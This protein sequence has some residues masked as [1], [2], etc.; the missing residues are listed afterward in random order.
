MK[1]T[2][3]TLSGCGDAGKTTMARHCIAPQRGGRILTFESRSA[4]GEESNPIDRDALVAHLFAAA[5]TG[6]VIDV[7]VGDV[8]D[9][10]EALQLLSRQ[11]AAIAQRLRIV[12]PLLAE[13]KSV[14]GLAWLLSQ[15][16]P[17][18][19]PAVR[20]IWNRIPPGGEDGLRTSDPCRAAR[21]LE[22]QHKFR[23]CGPAL[24]ESPLL[25]ATHSLLAERGSLEAI[26]SMRDDELRAAPLVEM[27]ALIAARDQAQLARANCQQVLVAIDE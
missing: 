3:M 21:G 27:P 7:G 4:R 8:L 14:Q 17:A 20:A 15:L 16:P 18:L 1:L 22:R 10:I 13:R 23:L 25:G 11:D 2:Y 26:A 24:H 12:T 19:R 6:A 5:E 9:A